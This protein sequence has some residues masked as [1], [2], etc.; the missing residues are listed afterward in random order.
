MKVSNTI[1]DFRL[2][3]YLN[4]NQTLNFTK[5]SFFY[6]ILG[7]TLSNLG[8][9]GDIDGYIQLIP[10][11]NRSIKPINFT[12]IDKNHSKCDC[13]NGSIVNGIRESIFLSFGLSSPPGQKIY[14]QPRVQL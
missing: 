7:Y 5:K 6:T 11:E 2:K 9:L 14:R 4:K 10:G 12:S 8:P 1:D 13:F 3:S